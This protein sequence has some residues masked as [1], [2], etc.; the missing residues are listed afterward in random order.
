MWDSHHLNNPIGL[1]GL[2]RV[3]FT[4]IFKAVETKIAFLWYPTPW[5][6][7]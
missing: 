4:F 3:S 2:L 1:H 6:P 7:A 5:E